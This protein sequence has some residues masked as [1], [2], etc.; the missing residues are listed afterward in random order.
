MV[1]AHC[2]KTNGRREWFWNWGGYPRKRRREGLRMSK[3]K[4]EKVREEDKQPRLDSTGILTAA[5]L[6]F[7]A[8][9]K[10]KT[11]N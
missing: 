9:K 11:V 8:F 3:E 2:P 7:H 5:V 1:S 4:G 6:L 10:K